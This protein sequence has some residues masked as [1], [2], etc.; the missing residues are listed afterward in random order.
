MPKF[1]KHIFW[2][3]FI[4]ID[5]AL[6]FPALHK[7]SI[8]IQAGF[9]MS[10]PVT[11]DLFLMARKV[12]AKGMVYGI[13]PDPKN[14]NIAEQ[15]C[16]DKKYACTLIQAGLHNR[17]GSTD[18]MLGEK[19]SWNQLADLPIDETVTFTEQNIR[20]PLYTLDELVE[21]YQIDI[22]R[23]R[24]IN[25][26]INGAE[27]AAL[28]GM[29]TLLQNIPDVCITVIAG[30]QD[31]SGMI[32]GVPDVECIETLL[33]QYGFKTRYRRI[34]QFFWWGFI[35]QFLMRRK[36]VYSTIQY[37]IVMA[38]KGRVRIPFY[39]SFS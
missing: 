11:S 25:L 20:V 12:G 36:P 21:K 13:D 24:H 26:T 2:S 27:Y 17:S 4:R 38:T 29:R 14:H 1:I 9:D 39:Q 8:G 19:A 31:A 7:G 6:K 33:Q 37:G 22:Q 16:A 34:D 18:L 28:E 15:I 3:I 5:A 32:N 35:V 30:R 23:I 10:A